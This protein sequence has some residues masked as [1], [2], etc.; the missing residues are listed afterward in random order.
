VNV[1]NNGGGSIT[2][3]GL[4]IRNAR[5]SGIVAYVNNVT[6]SDNVFTGNSGAFGGGVLSFGNNVVI[7]RNQFLHNPITISGGGVY[8]LG[9][10]TIA[11]NLFAGNSGPQDGSA[12]TASVGSSV[13]IVS[14]TI[15]GGTGPGGAIQLYGSPAVIA[16]NIIANNQSGINRNFAAAATVTLSHNDVFGNTSFN[17]Q[18]LPAGATDIAASPLFVNPG[19]DDY[20]LSTGS[21]AIDAG[22]DTFLS[23]SALDLAGNARKIGAHMDIGALEWVSDIVGVSDAARALRI[24]GG[25]I[26]ATAGDLTRLNVDNTTTSQNTVDIRDAVRLMRKVAG[27]DGNP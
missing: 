25:L 21:P 14:N 18:N 26:P 13:T 19:T 9:Q 8:V 15:T 1:Q 27:P 3:D 10:T 12:I 6:V 17:Y 5:G 16:N 11:N 20:R 4:T 24:A 23:V 7:S 22:D 2:F